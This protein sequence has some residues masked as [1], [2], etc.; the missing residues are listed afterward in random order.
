[1]IYLLLYS[2][3]KNFTYYLTATTTPNP[4]GTPISI[5]S[6]S[7]IYSA[8][9]GSNS[10]TCRYVAWT[11]STTGSVTLVFQFENDPDEWHMDDVSVSN[12]TTEMLLNGGFE[13]GSLSPSWTVS[14]PN[15]ACNLFAYGAAIDTSS[16]RSGSYCL[17]DGCGGRTDQISQSFGV[18]AGEIYFISFWLKQ[19]GS[20]SGISVSV[21]LS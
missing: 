14:T 5:G 15:G 9:S 1:M 11:A 3:S 19:G 18:T 12:G 20:G 6:S 8:L 4:C 21:T 7:S 10:Y 13:S 2:L 16:C 17:S